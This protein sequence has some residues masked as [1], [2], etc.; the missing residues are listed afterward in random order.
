[1]KGEIIKFQENLKTM[2]AEREETASDA[3]QLLTCI[4]EITAQLEEG[5]TGFDGN[6]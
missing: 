2:N 1:M 3:Q 4:E 6:V 5:D